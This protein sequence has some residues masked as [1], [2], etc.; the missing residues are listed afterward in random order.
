[1]TSLYVEYAVA[2]HEVLYAAFTLTEIWPRFMVSE[3]ANLKLVSMRN[4]TF[5]DHNFCQSGISFSV[6]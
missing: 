3:A 1:M 5:N 2:M 4:M 6:N